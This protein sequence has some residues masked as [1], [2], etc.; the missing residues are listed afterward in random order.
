MIEVGLILCLIHLPLF[1]PSS[2]LQSN[3]LAFKACI[4]PI[5]IREQHI[6]SFLLNL[7]LLIWSILG[8]FYNSNF[9]G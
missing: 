2:I 6:L 7:N 1:N 3:D 8:A 5:D 4:R 9:L